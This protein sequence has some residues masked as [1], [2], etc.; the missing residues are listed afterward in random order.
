MKPEL[1][2]MHGENRNMIERIR[3]SLDPV[4]YQYLM[5]G[6]ATVEDIEVFKNEYPELMGIWGTIIAGA[7]KLVGG[8]SRGIAKGVRGRRAR[9]AAAAAQK[10]ELESRRRLQQAALIHQQRMM[11]MAARQR[12]RTTSQKQKNMMMIALPLAGL[13]LFAMMNR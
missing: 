7:V 3:E 4:D 6:E 9:K 13:A 2:I 8:V 12:Q 11:Q 5:S 1:V 10:R